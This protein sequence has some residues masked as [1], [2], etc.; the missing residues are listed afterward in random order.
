[1]TFILDSQGRIWVVRVIW[2]GLRLA[3]RERVHLARL[4]AR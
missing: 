2:P 3:F 4:A 1:M